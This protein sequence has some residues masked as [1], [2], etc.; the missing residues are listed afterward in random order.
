M[1]IE[2]RNQEITAAYRAQGITG[3]G[4]VFDVLDTGIEPVGV[5]KDAQ[6][7]TPEYEGDTKGHGTMV[8]YLI[9]DAC[10]DA[11]IRS[12]CAI[13]KGYGTH[14]TIQA[15][16]EHVLEMAK[17]ETDKQHIVNM[18]LSGNYN[19]NSPETKALKQVI[20]D[21]TALNVQVVCA[22]GNDGKEVPNAVPGCFEAP[23][24][25]SAITAAGKHAGFSTL[26]DE[27]DFAE[28]GEDVYTMDMETNYVRASGTS[29]SSP[30]LAAKIGLVQS[31][32]K[33]TQ[34]RWLS[35]AEVYQILLDNVKDMGASGR[36]RIY[37]WG[38]VD[39]PAPAERKSEVNII[40]TGLVWPNGKGNLRAK[41]DHIQIHHTVGYYGTPEK[42][43]AL[44]K[45]KQAEGQR[46]VP[47]SF[48][49]KQNGEIYLGRGWEYSHGAV[50]DALTNNANQR[51]IAIALDGDMRNDNLPTEA[52]LQSALALVQEGMARYGVPVEKVIGHNE[53]P[54]SAGGTYKTEC[55]SMDMNDFRAMLKGETPEPKP[56]PEKPEPEKPEPVEFPCYAVY[57]GST[58]VNLRTSPSGEAIGKVGRGDRVVML[59]TAVSNKREWAEVILLADKPL[60]GWCVT[61][62]LER[63]G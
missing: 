18:S 38:F 53:V 56:E 16:L 10:P 25:A 59:Q 32:A 11:Q 39:L 37:G 3:K 14:K 28:H 60:R 40:D 26:H 47:Y 52:Q 29:F 42:W 50:K 44:H 48:L 9:K 2:K 51:S 41:T 5:L 35:D 8:A 6:N 21:L 36:D 46:G 4:L 30:I 1:D 23:Y 12:Y 57:A 13:P 24:T 45:S 17:Q 19:L 62:W 58:Y 54:L 22:A 34:G 15:C 33:E 31:H 27:V 49:V 61:D 43:N 55:P 7:M 63:E 20:N